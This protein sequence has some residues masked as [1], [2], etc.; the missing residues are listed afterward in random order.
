MMSQRLSKEFSEVASLQ[1]AVT[2]EMLP[3]VLGKP[4]RRGTGWKNNL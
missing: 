2:E 4:C 3:P 1:L